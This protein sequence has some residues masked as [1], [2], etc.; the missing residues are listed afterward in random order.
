MHTVLTYSCFRDACSWPRFTSLR[1][2][3]PCACRACLACHILS[4]SC[5]TLHHSKG[6]L[7]RFKGACLRSILRPAMSCQAV[8]TR[9][10]AA[11][12]WRKL[13]AACQMCM[14]K[15]MLCMQGPWHCSTRSCGAA[16]NHAYASKDA[17][18]ARRLCLQLPTLLAQCSYC[19]D[20][21]DCG[22]LHLL[23]FHRDAA[24]AQGLARVAEWVSAGTS[25]SMCLICLGSIKPSE[26]I[27]HCST[28]CY[29]VFHLPCMQVR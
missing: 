1:C 18:A 26:A 24:F 12:V 20:A 4:I 13:H 14:H 25:N 23:F 2:S 7:R 17:A 8:R 28:S 11:P 22:S 10:G 16:G 15:L 5:C 3:M 21:L 29:A 27:W 9:K 6:H 19:S